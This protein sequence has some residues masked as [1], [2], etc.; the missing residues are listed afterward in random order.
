MHLL[1]RTN[2]RIVATTVGG[3]INLGE[4]VQNQSSGIG[5]IIICLFTCRMHAVAHFLYLWCILGSL[6]L[7]CPGMDV[8]DQ[9]QT[10]VTEFL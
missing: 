6:V 10:P 5:F 7:F 9:L 8:M 4:L 1:A 2:C 3:G